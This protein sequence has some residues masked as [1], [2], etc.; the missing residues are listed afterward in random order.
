MPA[1][2][3]APPRQHLALFKRLWDVVDDKFHAAEA[4]TPEGHAFV[5][6]HA[7]KGSHAEFPCA[8]NFLAM[9]PAL[10]NGARAKLFPN[11]LS[12]LFNVFLNIN[13]AQTRKSSLTGS[14][15]RATE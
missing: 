2:S 6:T 14:A 11:G 10:T 5:Q 13:Y 3:A 8:M 9:M 7:I 4:L 15:M 12:P 1:S